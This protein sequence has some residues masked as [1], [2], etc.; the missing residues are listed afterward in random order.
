MAD[1][2]F[3]RRVRL[4]IA[5][6]IAGTFVDAVALLDIEDMRIQFKVERSLEKDPNTAQI[7]VTNLGPQTRAELQA[8]ALRVLLS[9]GYETTMAQIFAGDVRTVDHT[10]DGPEWNTKIEAGDGERALAHA[11]VNSS[12]APG[13]K[14]PKVVK[15]ATSAMGLDI[16]DV[17][18]TIDGMDGEYVNGYSA[19]GRASEE[20]ERILRRAGYEWS[21]Q[22]G[23]L[24]LFR[25]GGVT[26]ESVLDIGPDS[27]LVG[28]PEHGSPAH[29]GG[30]PTIKVRS[31]LEPEIRPGRR[32]QLTANSFSGL[33]RA[34]RV[35]HTGD[36]AGGDWYTEI[37]AE[38]FSP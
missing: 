38:A 19:R 36:T 31:L 6:P 17:E 4:S 23:K 18:D 12:H 35:T 1:L 24:Q 2:L 5:R 21:V 27:G 30:P 32:F 13:V 11:R 16:S 33:Y 7:V 37:E 20:L 34:L 14:L 8:K 10:H 26:S 15:T 22:D 3:K 9:A 28:S 25:S 29:K